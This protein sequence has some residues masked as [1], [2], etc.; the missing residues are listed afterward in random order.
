MIA[1]QFNEYSEIG[2]KK[3]SKKKE[4]KSAPNLLIFEYVIKSF[5]I[6]KFYYVKV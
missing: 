5:K 3:I 2:H 6:S 4:K 1:D